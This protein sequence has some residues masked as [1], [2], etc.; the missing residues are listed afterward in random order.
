MSEDTMDDLWRWEFFDN[1]DDDRNECDTCGYTL[2]SEDDYDLE[3]GP[4][5]CPSCKAYMY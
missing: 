3:N 5:Y 2:S 1:E 4:G